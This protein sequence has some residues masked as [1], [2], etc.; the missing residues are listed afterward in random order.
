MTDREYVLGVDSG[1]SGLRAALADPRGPGPDPST[2]PL[3]STGAVRSAEPVHTGPRGIDAGHF[4][5]QLL[6]MARA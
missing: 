4:L 2:E 3:H 6:P 5:K 1:G